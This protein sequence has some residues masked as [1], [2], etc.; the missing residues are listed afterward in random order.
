M[1]KKFYAYRKS[2]WFMLLNQMYKSLKQVQYNKIG[3][4]FEI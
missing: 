3:D 2:H 4:G 1:N